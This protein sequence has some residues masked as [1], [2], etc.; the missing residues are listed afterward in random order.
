MKL[1]F[2]SS[3]AARRTQDS[4]D[5]EFFNGFLFFI[6]LILALALLHIAVAYWLGTSM[7]MAI[8]YPRLEIILLQ[9]SFGAVCTAAAMALLSGSWQAYVAVLV[10]VLI[11]L[12]LL[13]FMGALVWSDLDFAV[14]GRDRT[15]YENGSPAA[16][17]AILLEFPLPAPAAP[18]D[19]ESK[20]KRDR[21][22]EP[23]SPVSPV[24]KQRDESSMPEEGYF[25]YLA[26]I[27]QVGTALLN[28]TALQDMALYCC[29]L[30]C[31][32]NILLHI[33]MRARE[34][35][36]SD[37]ELAERGV[38]IAGSCIILC[39]TTL[40]TQHT[41]PF[42]SWVEVISLLLRSRVAGALRS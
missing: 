10:L 27:L 41:T 18:D 42:Y 30:H 13:C 20:T 34:R 21:E 40:H 37:E 17:T 7:P 4:H 28:V 33:R 38:V 32:S 3:T 35:E 36:Q 1:P 6:T 12:P 39:Q 22:E 25:R 11:P 29:I 19:D 14:E 15:W 9:A 26:Q 31:I 16:A 24:S 2:G 5:H 23:L 8:H